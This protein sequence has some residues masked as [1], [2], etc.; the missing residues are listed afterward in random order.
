MPPTIADKSDDMDGIMMMLCN[1]RRRM[2][3]RMLRETDVG[4]R[5]AADQIAAVEHE[6]PSTDQRHAVYVSLQQTHIPTCRSHDVVACAGNGK[7][8]THTRPNICGR[9]GNPLTCRF[10]T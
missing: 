10:G 9:V 6:N 4:P 7:K 5:E 2:L 3:I 8:K 1:E